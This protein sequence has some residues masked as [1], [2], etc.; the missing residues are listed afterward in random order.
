MWRA[1]PCAGRPAPG[2]IAASCAARIE[3][4]VERHDVDIVRRRGLRAARRCAR[5]RA[6]R[7]GRRARCRP[8]PPAPRRIAAATASSTPTPG[9]RSACRISTGKLRP[10]LSIT[11]AS[12]SSSATRA[13]STVADMTSSRR[14]GRNAPCTSSASASPKSPSSERSWNSSKRMAA[15]PGSSGSSRIMRARMPS[16]TTRMRVLAETLRSMRM[17]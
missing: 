6:G 14:S 5:S 16:V 1:R 10:A 12:P 7:A 17:A 9:A 4:A 11:G 15:M 8:P 3:L 13:P 2:L